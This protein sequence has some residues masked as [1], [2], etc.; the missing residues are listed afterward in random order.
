MIPTGE[1]VFENQIMNIVN[2]LRTVEVN[3]EQSNRFLPVIMEA[4]KD[5][6]REEVIK[7]FAASELNR[8]LNQYEHAPDLNY[9]G[10]EERSSGRFDD[11]D[12]TEIFI[13][14]GDL[15]G[16]DRNNFLRFLKQFDLQNINVGRISVKKTHTYFSVA[17]EQ[18]DE[19]ISALSGH[20]VNG[21]KIRTEIT[22]SRGERESKSRF[23]KR[24]RGERPRK[25]RRY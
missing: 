8:F 14:I 10:G 24:G 25:K 20:S 18:V 17:N 23:D 9:E 5:M 11:R 16:L 21:R 2:N 22:G 13:S 4:M 7:K 1:E 3:E 6:D 19:V 12:M 15:E